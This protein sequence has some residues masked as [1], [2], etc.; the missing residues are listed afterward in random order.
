MFNREEESGH[1][2]S[3]VLYM[4]PYW[5]QHCKPLCRKLLKSALHR[6]RQ[7]DGKNGVGGTKVKGKDS[8][9]GT[10]VETLYS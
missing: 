1:K 6:G 2:G 5:Q 9:E 3:K 10:G 8:R 7:I 4:K